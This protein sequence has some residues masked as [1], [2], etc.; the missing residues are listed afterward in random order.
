MCEGILMDA[1]DLTPVL[2]RPRSSVSGCLTVLLVAAAIIIAYR[3][4]TPVAFLIAIG[5]FFFAF[6]LQAG[7]RFSQKVMKV[8]ATPRGVAWYHPVK[9]GGDLRWADIGALTIREEDVAGEAALILIPK[10]REQGET[11]IAVAGDLASSPAKG[12]ERLKELLAVVLRHIPPE[13]VIDRPTRAWLERNM[14]RGEAGEG[15]P[16]V[17]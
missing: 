7:V 6:V 11:L 1:P 10:G 12:R 15:P 13:T 2:P 16:S 8:V 9:G 14:G 3:R 17:E 5:L 4:R